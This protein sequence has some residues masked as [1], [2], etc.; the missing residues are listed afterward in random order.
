[1]ASEILSN[2]A[3]ST[4]AHTSLNALPAGDG[5]GLAKVTSASPTKCPPQ[6]E[7]FYQIT[8][9][10]GALANEL[11]EFY[12][13]RADAT[14]RDGNMLGTDIVL[15][16]GVAVPASQLQFVHA[17][18]LGAV[19]VAAYRGSFIVDNPGPDWQL[20]IQNATT[21]DLGVSAGHAI[22]YRTISPEVQ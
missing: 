11:I 18:V 2:Y 9:D 8:T 17:Q 15:G 14:T 6:V 5:A 1:M 13:G 21:G 4:I 3:A 22:T 19:P 12:I 7:I 16:A 10:T 20:L